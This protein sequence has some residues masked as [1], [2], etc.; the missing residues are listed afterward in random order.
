M[1][2]ATKKAVAP[3]MLEEVPHETDRSMPIAPLE[4]LFLVPSLRGGGAERVM[5]TLCRHLDRTCF[6]PSL[7]VVD[8]A[9]ASYLQDVPEDVEVIDL[10]SKRVRGAIPRILSLIW[11]R[12]P[13]IVFSTLGQLNLVLAAMRPLLP[14][15]VQYVAR[16]ASIVGLLPSVYNVPRWWFWAYRTLYPRFD[17]VVCQSRAMKDDLVENFAVPAAKTVVINNPVDIARIRQ[18]SLQEENPIGDTHSTLRLVAAGSLVAV[19]GFDILLAAMARLAVT[20]PF[21]LT[22]LGDGPLRQDLER[23]VEDL[24]L[25][26]CVR[27]VG[28]KANP[29][30]YFRQADAFVLCSRFEGFPNVVL[31]ALACGTPVVATPGAGGVR[32]VVEGIQGC[33][34]A[35]DQSPESLARALER[36]PGGLRVD[37]S[38]M[39]RYSVPSI[40]EQYQSMFVSTCAAYS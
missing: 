24:G 8:T 29:Y 34:L 21:C 12:R 23:Q 33:V 26:A 35:D 17:K 22:V 25:S 37:A 36:F 11:R 19:K 20:R 9:N 27:F 15:D 16:E 18:L 31:E 38:V 39:Q 13:R 4:I 7:A 5:V 30:P 40:V 2:H 1:R 28:F 10:H 3:L 32:E 6:R 14:R